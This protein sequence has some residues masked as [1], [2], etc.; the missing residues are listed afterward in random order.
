MKFIDALRNASKRIVSDLKDSDLFEHMGERGRFREF[1]IQELLRPHI[2]EA[3]GIGTGLVFD[4]YGCSSRQMDVVIYDNLFGNVLFREKNLSLYPCENVY[5]ALEVKSKLDNKQLDEAIVN[6][7]SL[8]LLSRKDATGLT[9]TPYCH[10]SLGDGLSGPTEKVNHYF[11]GVV[12][13]TSISPQTISNNLTS[14]LLAGENNL[15]NYVWIFKEGVFILG[16]TE[17]KVNGNHPTPL[18]IRPNFYFPVR[19]GDDTFPLMLTTINILLGLIRL[20]APEY[21]EY[22]KLMFDDAIKHS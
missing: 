12:A 16:I 20:K 8:K 3:Y 1:T 4:A 7:R 9:I 14:H 5:G 6:S 10:I 13:F 19:T 18:G 22:W 15:P 2:P 21:N 11:H 17:D